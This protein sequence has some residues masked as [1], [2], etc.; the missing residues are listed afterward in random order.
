MSATLLSLLLLATTPPGTDVDHPADDRAIYQQLEK[1]TVA[2]AQSGSPLNKAQRLKQCARDRTELRVGLPTGHSERISTEESYRR[3]ARSGLLICAVYNC[4]K[5]ERWH[6]TWSSG[7]VVHGSG[8]IA[9]NHHVAAHE[10]AEAM[11]ALTYDGRFLPVVEVLATRRTHD[12]AL[13]RVDLGGGSALTPLPLRDD[14][15]AGTKVLCYGNPGNGFGC[16]TEGILTR[17]VRAE[18][19]E[20]KGAVF[21]QISADYGG[22]S[23]GGPILDDCGNALGMAASTSPIL[24][25]AK[26]SSDGKTQERTLQMVRHNCVTGRAILDLTRIPAKPVGVK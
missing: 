25:P 26:T 11:G 9:T 14:A 16:L 10:S 19:S 13:L 7:F 4:G 2:L 18:G 5:C 1:A 22:G 3:A 17:Y 23:S 21:M 15:P 6:P 24:T 8:I 12:V 20:R